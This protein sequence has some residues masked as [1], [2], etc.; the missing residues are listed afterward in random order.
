M[1]GK[2]ERIRTRESCIRKRQKIYAN[3]RGK[4]IKNVAFQAIQAYIYCYVFL[5]FFL[6]VKELSLLCR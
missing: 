3:V 1:Q 2:T 5:Q 6:I 4:S